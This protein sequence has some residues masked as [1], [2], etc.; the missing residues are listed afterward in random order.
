MAQ[1]L[2]EPQ[3]AWVFNEQ[4]SSFDKSVDDDQHYVMVIDKGWSYTDLINQS[5]ALKDKS[6]QAIEAATGFFLTKA[7]ADE[8]GCWWYMSE[9]DRQYYE[10]TAHTRGNMPEAHS[11]PRPTDLD[12]HSSDQPFEP[13]SDDWVTFDEFYG[14]TNK[15]ASVGIIN[16]VLGAFVGFLLFPLYWVVGI[17]T[18]TVK[19]IQSL[20]GKAG[21]ES[22][23]Q[24]LIH[25]ALTIIP[26]L[27]VLTGIFD[28]LG[29]GVTGIFRVGQ[30]TPGGSRRRTQGCFNKLE[31]S[32]TW[33][34]TP[35][36]WIL[37]A[38]NRL[39]G[40]ALNLVV[41]LLV[42]PVFSMMDWVRKS[43]ERMQGLKAE[44]V[45]G[46]MLGAVMLLLTPFAYVASVL[47]TIPRA[48]LVGG[49]SG[50]IGLVKW[51]WLSLDISLIAGKSDSS[52]QTTTSELVGDGVRFSVINAAVTGLV[53]GAWAMLVFGLALGG[54]AVGIPVIGPVFGAIATVGN[55][56]LGLLPFINSAAAPAIL[57]LDL[58]VLTTLATFVVE[59][60][61]RG[62]ALL[63][64]VV[65]IAS[66]GVNELAS[67]QAGQK[68]DTH[69]ALGAD[70]GYRTDL[71][72]SAV[73]PVARAVSDKLDSCMPCCCKSP[74]GVSNLDGK[75]AGDPDDYQADPSLVQ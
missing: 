14:L 28:S 15:K 64:A 72:D 4:Y 52:S 8:S 25:L 22:A 36:G 37:F 39:L 2:M 59:A 18:G 21:E 73:L 51:R 49:R 10:S 60:A 50:I 63:S 42:Y 54:V 48:M 65:G 1:E 55:W 35:Q 61:V 62:V 56:V 68:L 69:A 17:A 13:Q 9:D 40:I 71:Y 31:L 23:Y 19:F 43:M 5:N 70:Y 32:R 46:R 44:S 58:A 67:K 6:L 38:M 12:T 7:L 30:P 53:I 74:I 29:Y 75:G 34:K 3:A 33:N 45:L 57:A 47:V 26:V 24:N 66:A 41:G 11:L 16:K 27:P 20:R